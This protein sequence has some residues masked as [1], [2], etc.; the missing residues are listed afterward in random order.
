MQQP[1]LLKN[2]LLSKN[3][4]FKDRL[5]VFESLDAEIDSDDLI[6]IVSFK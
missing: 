3:P 1:F 5:F 6:G 4:T 2:Q